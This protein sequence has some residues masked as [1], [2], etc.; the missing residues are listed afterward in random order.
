MAEWLD[1]DWKRSGL[2]AVLAQNDEVAIGIMDAIRAAGLRVP[3]DISVI[4]FDGTEEGAHAKPELTTV[5]VPL[6][7]IGATAMELLL[8]QV[9]EEPVEA[10]VITLPSRLQ[11]RA[12]TANTKVE[13]GAEVSTQ[14]G[15]SA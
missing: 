2:T 9:R 11:V 14:Q 6:E 7:K 5:A 8:R 15:A 1:K 10:N 12:S 4:G 3:N 13:T